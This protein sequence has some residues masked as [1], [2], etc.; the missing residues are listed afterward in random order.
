M[1]GAQRGPGFGQPEDETLVAFSGFK[2]LNTKPD[3]DQIDDQELFWCHNMQPVANGTLR[4]VAGPG[5][6]LWT[7]PSGTTINSFYIFDLGQTTYFCAIF[8]SDGSLKIASFINPFDN[9]PWTTIYDSA[10]HSILFDISF[11]PACCQWGRQYLLIATEK[12]A[13]YTW[14]GT[15]LTVVSAD[16]GG[17][18]IETYQG[19][20]WLGLG[21]TITF[22]APNSATDFTPA[23]GA[24]TFVSTDS[25]LQYSYYGIRQAN[26]FLY[27]IADSSVNYISGVS[28]SGSPPVTTFTNLNIDPQNGTIAPGSVQL[29]GRYIMCANKNGIQAVYGGA[30]QKVSEPLDGFFCPPINGGP[31]G[32]QV[33]L[34]TSG[35]VQLCGTTCFIFKCSGV[36]NLYT[37]Q[38]QDMLMLYDGKR[39]FTADQGDRGIGFI[40]PYRGNSIFTS[41]ATDGTGTTIYQMFAGLSNGSLQRQLMSKQFPQPKVAYEKRA[42]NFY[43]M[44]QNYSTNTAVD[45][46][47]NFVDGTGNET[48]VS[49]ARVVPVGAKDFYYA[50][51]NFAG[52]EIGLNFESSAI[53]FSLNTLEFGTQLYSR[54][55]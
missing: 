29:F 15:T 20:V 50:E 24:G 19:R 17:R 30:V 5:P 11:Y 33:Q 44:L 9:T 12:P 37:G 40:N 39:W 35:V 55:S 48:T 42:L 23:D 34:G 6:T 41:Y 32:P 4:A 1:S 46:T 8:L 54:W 13:Y 53:D 18:T 36:P 27:L 25:F 28:T 2:T 52:Q 43:H 26:G 21:A 31:T 3:R 10:S 22:S 49:V 16:I 38:A 47:L 45:Y 7:A 51:V 14:D